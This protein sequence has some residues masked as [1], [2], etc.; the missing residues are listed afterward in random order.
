MDIQTAVELIN[1]KGLKNKLGRYNSRC[2]TEDW[3]NK[4][5]LTDLYNFIQEAT[6]HIE[7]RS[8]GERLWALEHWPIP[9]CECGNP[10][11]RYDNADFWSLYCSKKC[12]L[13]SSKRAEQ[14]SK[15][16]LVADH[17]KSNA[18]RKSTM[19]KKYGTDT[20]SQREDVKA[21]LRQRQ[22]KASEVSWKLFMDDGWIKSQHIDDDERS[23]RSIARYLGIDYGIVLDRVNSLG[24]LEVRN[25]NRSDVESSI[26][27]F[28]T[29]LGYEVTTSYRP[30]WMGGR[31]ELD[32]IIPNKALAI[33]V[34]GI[35]YHSE[36]FKADRKYHLN[37]LLSCLD[38]GVRLFQIT[39]WEWYKK[40]DIVKSMIVNRL[41]GS[42]KVY[43]RQCN[44]QQINWSTAKEFLNQCHISGCG[45]PSKHCYGLYHNDILIT[46]ATFGKSRFSKLADWELLRFASR[47]NMTV[48]GGLAKIMHHFISTVSTSVMTYADRR[49]GE[50]KAYAT[51]GMT[52]KGS[53][54]C[55][56]SWVNSNN[57]L[58]RY[59][60]QK[61]NLSSLLGPKFDPMVSEAVNMERAGY[62]RL[63]DCGHNIY[64]MQ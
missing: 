45:T 38:N 32:I 41:G 20:N 25:Y 58:S 12:A 42:D 29:S 55:G 14:I 2:L 4:N 46:V 37:K 5:G 10:V 16:K 18:K 64:V 51:I 33:E 23:V 52:Y 6:P 13:F 9:L 48:V 30:E 1:S 53:T 63:W 19:Q 7:N 57:L 22:T 24:I 59:A 21:I 49:Y 43:A 50:G 44:L 3:F 27:Q 62:H 11:K 31:K 40:S 54:D 60:T 17:T 36:Q 47:L 34:N 61:K 39:D 26:E 28:I 56:Y 8:L 15:T 35:R